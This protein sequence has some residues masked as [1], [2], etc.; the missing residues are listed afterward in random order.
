MTRVVHAEFCF[1]FR[2]YAKQHK[3]ETPFQKVKIVQWIILRALHIFFFSIQPKCKPRERSGGQNFKIIIIIMIGL[4]LSFKIPFQLDEDGL[5]F[6]YRAQVIVNITVKSKD[7]TIITQILT[8]ENL[9]IHVNYSI[10]CLVY[11]IPGILS[12]QGVFINTS[13]G[14]ENMPGVCQ[15]SCELF[16][17]KQNTKHN[18]L[19]YHA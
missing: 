13:V 4:G 16:S 1:A 10:I 7:F 9:N 15:N 17:C 11:F 3:P 12:S 18:G 5:Y 2:A 14:V 19:Y 6:S 8:Y